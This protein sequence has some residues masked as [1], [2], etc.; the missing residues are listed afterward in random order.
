MQ[1]KRILK[2]MMD[3]MNAVKPPRMTAL[4]ELHEAETGGPFSILIGTI[5]SARTKDENTTKVV[6][7]LF[8]RYKNAKELANKLNNAMQKYSEGEFNQAVFLF[9]E[10]GDQAI[11]KYYTALSYMETSR[12]SYAIPLFEGIILDKNNLFIE[13]SEWYLGLCYIKIHSFDKADSLFVKISEGSSVY[14][15]SASEIADLLKKQ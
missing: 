15:G 3:T 4:R 5:L 12:Y 13:R 8:S 11:A 1:M 2:G 9:S 10:S 7:V 6:K 14:K